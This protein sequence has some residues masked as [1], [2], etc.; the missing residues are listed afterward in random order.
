MRA[1]GRITD[2]PVICSGTTPRAV[3]ASASSKKR[4]SS[5]SMQACRCG[6]Q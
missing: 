4:I 3:A 6:P 1:S 5:R 2:I